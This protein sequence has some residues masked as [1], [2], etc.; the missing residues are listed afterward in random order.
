MRTLTSGAQ[1]VLAGSHVPAVLLIEMSFSPVLRVTTAGADIVYGG[2]TYTGVGSLGAV[3]PVKDST[4]ETT[5]LT[6]TLSGVPSANLSLALGVSA[7]GKTC[8]IRLGILN[9][10]TYAIEDAPL[11]GTF[12]LDQ[13]TIAGSTISVSCQPMRRLFAMPKFLRYTDGDQ[14]I[15]SAGDR[16][17]EYLTSQAVTKDIWPAASWGK[18]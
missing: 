2:N 10:T 6:F 12:I 16:A 4:S 18:Q 1:S 11:L 14:Q 7:R 13:M 17:L 3:E 15:V 5:G 8:S 9:A